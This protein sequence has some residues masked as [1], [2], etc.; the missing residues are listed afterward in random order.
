MLEL[1]NSSAYRIRPCIAHDERFL[2]FSISSNRH[3]L[4][5]PDTADA[6]NVIIGTSYAMGFGVNCG[7]NWYEL[8]LDAKQ[9]FNAGLPAGPREWQGVLNEDYRGDF[10]HAVFL[11]HPNVIQHGVTF[12]KWRSSDR[13][14]FDYLGWKTSLVK[15]ARLKLRQMVKHRRDQKAGR[16]LF[17]R[18]SQQKWKINAGYSFLKSADMAG[19]TDVVDRLYHLFSQ[20]KRVTVVRIPIKEHLVPDE[21]RNPVLN[22]TLEQHQL[23]WCY[24]RNRLKNH[25]NIELLE[26]PLTDIVHFNQFDTHWSPEGN[27]AFAD[28]FKKKVTVEL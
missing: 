20:F 16:T 1:D 28:Y 14:L 24:V 22:Q 6:S 15:C 8:C 19:V 11:Y 23:M 4:R 18:R 17:I 25:S 26:Y 27:R 10:R 7:F 2:G 21:D 12:E 9:W 3:G 13:P 5:G